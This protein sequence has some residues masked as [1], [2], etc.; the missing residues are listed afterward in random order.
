MKN[1]VFEL[2]ELLETK[3]FTDFLENLADRTGRTYNEVYDKVLDDNIYCEIVVD[4]YLKS[5]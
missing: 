5:L 2:N 3:S 4:G 1:R